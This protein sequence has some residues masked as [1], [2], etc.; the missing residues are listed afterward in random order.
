MCTVNSLAAYWLCFFRNSSCRTVLIAYLV[1]WGLDSSSARANSTPSLNF[2]LVAPPD[3]TIQIKRPQACDTLFN[4]PAASVNYSG[5]C[6]T[7]I[8]YTTSN[9]FTALNTNGGILFFTTG[10][11][12]VVYTVTDHCGMTGRDSTYVTVYDASVPNL[13]CNPQQTIN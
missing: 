13:V 4:M 1:C 9:V 11:Y 5:V 8:T 6:P 2:Q 3:I 7:A 10:V 12:K